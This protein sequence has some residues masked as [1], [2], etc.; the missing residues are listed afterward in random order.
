[1]L[2]KIGPVLAIAALAL[3]PTHTLAASELLARAVLGRCIVDAIT[4]GVDKEVAHAVAIRIH[5]IFAE[6]LTTQH[7]A[8]HLALSPTAGHHAGLGVGAVHEGVVT[9]AIAIL[10]HEVGASA[11]ACAILLLPHLLA[12]LGIGRAG[13]LSEDSCA[14][15]EDHN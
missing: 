7:L 13:A 15:R 5:E 9:H 12:T 11:Q 3:H 14:D 2:E 6:T 1:M 8:L 4:V 10:V